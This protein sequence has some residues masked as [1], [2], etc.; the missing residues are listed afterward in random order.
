[1]DGWMDNRRKR[2]GG[3]G[4]GMGRKGKRM[5]KENRKNRKK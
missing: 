5:L 3:T 2:D 1:M 4:T